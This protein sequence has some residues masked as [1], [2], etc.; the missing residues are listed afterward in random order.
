[1]RAE[2]TRPVK[3]AGDR[4]WCCAL[5][6]IGPER[7][8]WYHRAHH[9]MLDGFGGGL[10]V[11]RVAEIYSCLSAGREVAPPRFGSLES[12]IG[13]DRDYRSSAR[14]ERDR[15]RAALPVP[16]T[17]LRA[18]A[19][20]HY[21]APRT[22]GEKLLAELWKETFDL[23]Q[24]SVHDNFFAFGGD[25]L[26]AVNMVAELSERYSIEL[27]VSAVFQDPTIANLARSIDGAAVADMFGTIL[28]LR[29]GNE[30]PA[31]FCVHPVAGMCWG[32]AGLTR[33]LAPAQSIYGLQSI[34]LV[35][36]MPTSIEAMALRY[37]EEMR[38][39]QPHG[40][41]MLVGW[42]L[43]GL[44]AHEIAAHLCQNGEEVRLLGMLDSYPFRFSEAMDEADV[45]A[46]SLGFLGYPPDRL[47]GAKR[48]DALADLLTEDDDL[49]FAGT[50]WFVTSVLPAR[51]I[52][53]EYEP[54]ARRRRPLPDCLMDAT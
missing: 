44:V 21:V 48:I 26:S 45:V 24:V 51:S 9:I 27:P 41:Y 30:A 1:M 34:G 4:L 50:P 31:L 40:P 19:G 33:Y 22:K 12:L 29:Q 8:F 2:L 37:V 5:F 20:E 42:S 16:E 10:I 36:S 39:V 17:T 52:D 11:R 53:D 6:R 18:T 7:W 54:M 47:N 49:I 15:D 43:G 3:L 25:S 13:A 14:F 35:D 32:Y 28:P 23:A 38:K 46:A